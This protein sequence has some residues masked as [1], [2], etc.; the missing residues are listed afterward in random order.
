[1]LAPFLV[2][3][4]ALVVAPAIAT[5]VLALFDY[6][7]IR[8]PRWIAL[9]NFSELLGDDVF[10]ISLRNSMM[11]AALAV[12]LRL[13]GALGLALLLH[14]RSRGFGAYR[15][16]AL[17]PSV[18]PDVA[19][20][21]VWLWLLNPLYG[22]INLA[23]DAVGA[24]TPAW[25]TEP[26][27]AQAAI[28]GMSL[29]TIGEGFIVLLAARSEIPTEVYD[30]G[31]LDGSGAWQLFRRVTLPMLVPTLVLLAARDTVFAFQASFVPALVVT[32]GGPPPFSTTYLPVFVYRN[33]F[34]YLR[35][36]YAAAAT[37]A[38]LAVTGL[39]LLVQSSILTRRR[40]HW[41]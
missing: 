7:L 8:S 40:L 39:M 21:L 18:I 15:A 29:F 1:M 22:P 3:A 41:L 38:M 31:R 17:L 14:H 19:Y 27:A 20:G 10:R 11:F 36:G 28:I 37:V 4:V 34:E 5:L 6:D 9:G 33:A 26:A 16:A 23:L 25:L 24:P 32:D 2:G 35:Y 13:G 30:L 12:P